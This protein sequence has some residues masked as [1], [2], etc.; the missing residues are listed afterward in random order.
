MLVVDDEPET[1]GALGD[2]VRMAAPDADVRIESSPH[3]ALAR[4]E[5][6][7]VALVVSDHRMPLMSGLEL[8]QAIRRVDPGVAT[9]M[10]T[11]YPDPQLAIRALNEAGVR[12]FLTKPVD[13]EKLRQV[14]Q[15]F[16]KSRGRV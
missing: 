2:F 1:L 3:A 8:L 11:A 7:G 12:A 16:A 15:E 14:V 5:R 9:V 4:V 13:P 6:G 10:L